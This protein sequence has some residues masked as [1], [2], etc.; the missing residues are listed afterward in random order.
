MVRHATQE[1]LVHRGKSSIQ[2][3][4]RAQASMLRAA[5]TADRSDA[6]LLMK[7]SMLYNKITKGD[8]DLDKEISIEMSE[9]EN[10]EYVYECCTYR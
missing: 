10:T 3:A 8:Y 7:I 1:A 2:A 9:S 5:A 4:C 6:D